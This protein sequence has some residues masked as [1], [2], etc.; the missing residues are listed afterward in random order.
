MDIRKDF[1]LI[2][3]TFDGKPLVYLDSAATTQKPQVVIDVLSEYYSE[4]NANIHRGIYHI[5]EKATLEFEAVRDRV[6]S[7]INAED[8]T[9]IIFTKGTTESI[10]LVA[11]SWGR[12]FLKSGDEILITEMEHHSNNVPWQLV[13]KF[14]GATLKYI[15]VNEDGEL[16]NPLQYINKNTKLV[17]VIHQSN[18]LG[19]LNPVE[20]I[21]SRAHEVGA[22]VLV[23]GAQSTPHLPIDVQDMDCDFFTFSG[24]KMMGPTGVGVL[25]GKQ[26]VLNEMDPFLGGGEMIK[27]VSMDAVSFNELPWKFEAGTPNIA[28]VIGLG[29]AIDYINKIGLNTIY[30]HGE[31][32]K[33]YA[34]ERISQIDNVT[35]YGHA[36]D[37][38]PVLSF[39]IEGIHPHD[40]AQLLD[41]QHI[42]IRVGHHCAQPL[43]T[44]FGITSSARASF[45]VYNTTEEIDIL[46]QGIEKAVSIL[47]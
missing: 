8:R 7:F 21:I 32:L 39:N 30:Q 2:N 19:T 12:K 31:L 42:C 24:H 23:D 16:E 40:L 5:A 22:K 43:L 44:K 35:I 11:Y 46:I 6:T 9:E 28:Q 10:N 47:K 26:E 15:P 18:V 41:Q 38:G 27:D 25:Y 4:Y 13:A 33:E 17:A 37:R 14:T 36:Q 45:Y 20:T 3:Q 34:L 1:P 29:S